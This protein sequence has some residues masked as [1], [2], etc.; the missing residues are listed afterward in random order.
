MARWKSAGR[1][2]AAPAM[3]VITTD[4][5]AERDVNYETR[6]I[7]AHANASSS[8]TAAPRSTSPVSLPVRRSTKIYINARIMDAR[9]NVIEAQALGEDQISRVRDCYCTVEDKRKRGRADRWVD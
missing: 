6:G 4:E 3:I 2:C 7:R 8:C 1:G 9:R 5:E